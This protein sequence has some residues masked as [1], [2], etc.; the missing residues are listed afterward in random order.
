[1]KFAILG[2]SHETN[3][4]SVVPATYSEFEKSGILRGQ[5][6]LDEFRDSNYTIAG[7]LQAAEELGFE[8]IP[9]MYASTG[10]IGTS[11]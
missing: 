11:T 4:F 10:P 7:Y 8:A 2:I 6:I 3:T 9:L 1:M 5:Q